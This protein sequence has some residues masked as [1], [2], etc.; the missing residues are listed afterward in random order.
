MDPLKSLLE[1]Q[2]V[3][4]GLADSAGHPILTEFKGTASEQALRTA[5]ETQLPWTLHVVSRDPSAELAQLAA[6]RY[7][8]F[9][10]LAT[11]AIVVLTGIYF[12]ARAV[13]RELQVARLQS[14]FVSAVSHEFRTPLTS[15]RQLTELLASGRVANR[16]RR[17]KYYQVLMRES[18][19]LHRFVEGLL[20]FGR[21][22][23][24][25]QEYRMEALDAAA[26]VR[27]VVGEFQQE[28]E[29]RGYSVGLRLREATALVRGDREALA[30]ALWNLLDNAVKYSPSCQ[31][32][33]VEV[34][35]EGEQLAIEV[36]DRGLG[37]PASEQKEIFRK[38][39]RG[40]SSKGT[41]TKG[42]GIGLAMVDHIITD[43]GGQITLTSE[44]GAGSAF[45]IRLPI[46]E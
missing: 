40:T 21:M 2:G 6:R 29:D 5:A 14:D 30:R 33:W 25:A 28:I 12:I 3:K 23:A 43:H 45:T 8:V 27:D 15:V 10:G 41:S 11:A 24:G 31:T 13:R 44:P 26:L 17:Q 19:R 39:V 9:S 46:K 37:I 35:R 22:E 32:V 42:T 1:R 16:E 36:R 4:L 7:L 34:R 38:F 18:Q 20:D